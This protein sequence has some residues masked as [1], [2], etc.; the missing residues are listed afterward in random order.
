MESLSLVSIFVVG[1]IGAVTPGPD[2]LLVL[3]YGLNFGLKHSISAF[4]GIASGWAIFLSAIYL[5][6][7][8][9]FNTPMFQLVLS[10]AGGLYLSYLS[11][12]MLRSKVSKKALQNQIDKKENAP[13]GIVYSYF[14][15]LLINLSNPKAIL[16]FTTI[17]VPFMGV[18]I[19]K[20][21]LV[22]F[23]SLATPFCLVIIVANFARRLVTPR[24]FIWI[25]RICGVVFGLF[26]L[27]LL[28]SGFLLAIEA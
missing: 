27:F 13:K 19:G 5:G 28:Y 21:L 12:C 15:A 20:P 9:F 3:R 25:D 6:L 24:V 10:F 4:L 14:K 18:D 22:L 11:I 8:A 16:F 2:I 7:S 1:F 23:A 17:I 26:G